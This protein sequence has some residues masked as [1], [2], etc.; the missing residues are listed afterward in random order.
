VPSLGLSNKAV[1]AGEQ[2]REQQEKHVKDVYP[3][4]YFS[5]ELSSKP[6]A[7]EA[8][9]QNTLWPE[10][11]KLYGHGHELFTVASAPDSS[12]VASSCRATDA[13]SARVILWDPETWTEVGQVG[14][15]S[16]T[17]T[18]LAFSPC[19]KM[20]LAVSRDRTWSLHRLC[21]TGGSL[22]TSLIWKTDKKTAVHS[23][24]IW[25]AAWTP[26]G[27]FFGTASRDKKVVIWGEGEGGT[28]GPQ[29]QPLVLGDSVT[30]LAM[31][32]AR[33]EGAYTVACGQESGALAL[34]T[35]G[36]GGGWGA[37]HS[38]KLHMAT[39]TRLAW[40]PSQGEEGLELA[41]CSADTSVSIVRVEL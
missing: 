23:R 28:W 30:A 31:A 19:S 32:P 14:G 24:I 6:P 15:H 13:T 5:K 38:H 33:Q 18:Q 16:L 3:D 17:V 7:E 25:A 1:F 29:G 41:S 22:T 21:R 34:C 10:V 35:W 39:V 11:H 12:L 20:L 2:E 26:D 40:R 27:R 4:S 36:P 37:L 9:V 8:L